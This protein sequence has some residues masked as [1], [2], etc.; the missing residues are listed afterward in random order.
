M[1]KLF[2]VL[3]SA[4]IMTAFVSSCGGNSPETVAEKAMECLKSGDL[5]GYLS[6]QEEP[7]PRRVQHIFKC[8]ESMNKGI[9][10]Y[11]IGEIKD[12]ELEKMGKPIYIAKLKVKTG[13]GRTKDG[14]IW[15]TKDKDGNFKL[16]SDGMSDWWMSR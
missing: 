9:E 14:Q 12:L 3:V 15:L 1:K 11:E 6:L 8:I 10:S 13:R 5:E 4:L 7:D 16:Q 2:A